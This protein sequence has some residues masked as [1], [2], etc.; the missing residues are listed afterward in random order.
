MTTEAS[1]PP[2]PNPLPRPV[3]G[4]LSA[5]DAKEYV[6]D[7]AIDFIGLFDARD[8]EAIV[9]L[10]DFVAENYGD[11]DFP[12]LGDSEDYALSPKNFTQALAAAVR[13]H[14]FSPLSRASYRYDIKFSDFARRIRTRPLRMGK[15]S[16]SNDIIFRFRGPLQQLQAK[17]SAHPATAP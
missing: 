6:E 4:I 1:L 9:N 14:T 13:T 3:E 8:Q 15:I 12:D 5:E 17:K 10:A 11:L 7:T 2:D 16:G